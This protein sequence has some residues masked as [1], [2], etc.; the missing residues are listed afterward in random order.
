MAA[1]LTTEILIQIRDE[2]RKTNERLDR[3]E[4]RQNESEIRVA[5]EIIALAG[6]VREVRDLFK[7]DR[8]TREAVQKHET[9]FTE[10]EQRLTAVER[11]VG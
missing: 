6:V 8:A 5:T 1:D 11:K 3:V 2:I 4:K 7:E 9:R 10:M